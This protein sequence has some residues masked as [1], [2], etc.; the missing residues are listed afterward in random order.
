M[1]YLIALQSIGLE[2]CVLA[3]LNH[4]L[5]ESKVFNY[6][7]FKI[8][9][10]LCFVSFSL[11]FCFIFVSL[12]KWDIERAVSKQVRIVLHTLFEKVVANNGHTAQQ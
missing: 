12:S 2:M 8:E 7:L 6:C 10:I 5:N 1:E 4:K 11:I 9:T 3:C